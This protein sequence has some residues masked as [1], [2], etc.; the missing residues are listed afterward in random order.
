MLYGFGQQT[1]LQYGDAI[2]HSAFQIEKK[3]PF[4]MQICPHI[5]DSWNHPIYQT[6]KQMQNCL[7]LKS[8]LLSLA[9]KLTLSPKPQQPKSE[10]I[11]NAIAVF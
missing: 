10:I 3:Y 4:R 1:R 5:N 8:H 9:F 11:Q 7:K 2:A 6:T